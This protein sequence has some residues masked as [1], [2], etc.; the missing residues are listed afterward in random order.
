[1]RRML[2]ALTLDKVKQ[3][4]ALT[5]LVFK[6][7]QSEICDV[8]LTKRLFKIAKVNRNS[9]CACGAKERESV[10]EME[11]REYR[12]MCREKFKIQ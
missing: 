2:Y 4:A 11:S 9:C 5:G 6:C 3:H 1:M 12:A 8:L 7:C 10:R